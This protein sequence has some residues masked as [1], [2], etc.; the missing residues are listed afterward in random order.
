MAAFSADDVKMR[1]PKR[2]DVDSASSAA[3]PMSATRA[4]LRRSKPT[5]ALAKRCN[6]RVR[7]VGSRPQISPGCRSEAI[8]PLRRLDADPR[9]PT[10]SIAKC[11]PRKRPVRFGL[12][13]SPKPSF[14]VGR[15]RPTRR[16]SSLTVPALSPHQQHGDLYVSEHQDAAQLRRRHGEGDP[17]VVAAFVRKLSASKPFRRRTRRLARRG[18]RSGGAR[19]ARLAGDARATAGSRRRGGEGASPRPRSALSRA[20]LT[21]G[22]L[23]RAASRRPGARAGGHPRHRHGRL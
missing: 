13:P 2:S 14:V 16:T 15:T 5:G 9:S 18:E 21:R 8:S 23:R 3:S 17:R 12:C 1:T 20:R 22:T 11:S 4:E 19:A 7:A 6:R 10:P